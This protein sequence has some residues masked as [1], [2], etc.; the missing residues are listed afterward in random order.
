MLKVNEIFYSLQGEGSRVG[1]PTIF[2]R[3]SGCNLNCSWCDTKHQKHVKLD[4][5]K[6]M[7]QIDQLAKT[8]K[9]VCITGGEPLVQDIRKLVEQLRFY[10]LNVQLETNGLLF[11]KNKAWEMCDFITISPKYRDCV[12]Y[13]FL[14]PILSDNMRDVEIKYVVGT[15][16]KDEIRA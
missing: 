2:I 4:E 5:D 14:W 15:T 6:I 12:G 9:W 13:K 1:Q 16:E 11:E 10:N 3:L 8:V 7:E